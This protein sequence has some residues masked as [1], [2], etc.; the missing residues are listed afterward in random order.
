MYKTLHCARIG[1]FC[2]LMENI[3][4]GI[5]DLLLA[6][7]WESGWSG[8]RDRDV[9]LHCLTQ[10]GEV[11]LGWPYWGCLLTSPTSSAQLCQANIINTAQGPS[12]PPLPLHHSTHTNTPTR[13]RIHW[14]YTPDIVVV[15]L[16]LLVVPSVAH[17]S[18]IGPA[19]SRPQRWCTPSLREQNCREPFFSNLVAKKLLHG[20]TPTCT[21]PTWSLFLH[22]F[23]KFGLFIIKTS[24]H[25]VEQMLRGWHDTAAAFMYSIRELTVKPQH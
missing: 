22:S 19:S 11:R 3:F 18:R 16:V 1:K 4:H 2:Q 10:S 25:G 6:A 7:V 23:Y 24:K 17:W 8:R 9:G 21:V 20:K 5:C 14:L 12:P 15:L 13:P